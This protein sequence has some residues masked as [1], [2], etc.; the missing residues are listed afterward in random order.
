MQTT[1]QNTKSIRLWSVKWT[2]DGVDYWLLDA[3]KMEIT[4]KTLALK[5]SNGELPPRTKP[6]SVKISCEMYE[7]HLPNVKTL[8]TSFDYTATVGSATPVTGES[9]KLAAASWATWEKI[10]LAN[11]NWDKTMVSTLVVKNWA[12]TL[13]KDTDYYVYTY[14]NGDVVLE[15]K[16]TALT[17]VSW[18]LTA[19]YSY[20]PYTMHTLT[21]KDVMKIAEY[22]LNKFI[23]VDENG[24]ELR[25]IMPKWFKSNGWNL[26]FAS[27]QEVDQA[28]KPA[29]EITA[30]AN[31][32]NVLLIIEDEQSV[33]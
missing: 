7:F 1:A 14:A 19:D 8:D 30:S 6:D 10:I 24:K 18:W 26:E 31:D 25:I 5:A 27:D 13:T 17:I 28:M 9:L 21:L 11:K 3:A 2:V 4:Y 20:T 15:R 22:R 32:D 33:D 29:I 16:W 23:S 12:G